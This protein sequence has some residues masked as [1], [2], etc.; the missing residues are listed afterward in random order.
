MIV[1][2]YKLN[3][4]E[5]F[6]IQCQRACDRVQGSIGLTGTFQINVRN[7]VGKFE[8]AITGK[9]VEDQ[10]KVLVAFDIA[11]TLEEFVQDGTNDN[12]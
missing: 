1:D 5:L 11:G 9:T 2:L 8:F 10:G 3:V 7:T 12:S 6:E 4:G